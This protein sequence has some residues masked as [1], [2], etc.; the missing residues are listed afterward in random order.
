[1]C[2]VFVGKLRG[3]VNAKGAAKN[4]NN[5]YT[6]SGMYKVTSK[7]QPEYKTGTGVPPVKYDADMY[8]GERGIQGIRIKSACREREDLLVCAVVYKY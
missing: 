8:E 2:V 5:Q 1:M 4:K 7:H 3:D 6:T